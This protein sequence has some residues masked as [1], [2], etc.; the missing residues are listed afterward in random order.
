[1]KLTKPTFI[2]KFGNVT[3]LNLRI[4]SKKDTHQR[5]NFVKTLGLTTAAIGAAPYILKGKPFSQTPAGKRVGIIGLD[6]S[7][8]IAF[9]KAMNQ[10]NHPELLGYK[11]IAAYPHGSKDIESRSEE[12]RVGKECRVGWYQ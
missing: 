3:E 9:T 7:H 6:T 2:H 11:V 1:M 8:S 10:E 12:R 4:M 5:R